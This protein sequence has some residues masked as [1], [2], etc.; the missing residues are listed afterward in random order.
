[1]R[2]IRIREKTDAA[3]ISGIQGILDEEIDLSA[4][5]HGIVL[6]DSTIGL[7]LTTTMPTLQMTW[8][9]KRLTVYS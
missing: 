2:F 3:S 9:K 4:K 5:L 8:L 6:D 1:M 7:R